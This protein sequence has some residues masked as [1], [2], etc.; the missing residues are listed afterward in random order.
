MDIFYGRVKPGQGREIEGFTGEYGMIQ[1]H[2]AIENWAAIKGKGF[3]LS[4]D[5][6]DTDLNFKIIETCVKNGLIVD[7][8]L[9]NSHSMRIAPPLIITDEEIKNACAIIMQSIFEC[10]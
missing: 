6:E 7:W 10:V 2:R 4:L 9:F 8:F 1:F 5:F 3:M